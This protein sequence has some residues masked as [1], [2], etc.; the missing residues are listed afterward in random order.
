MVT[1][2]YDLQT[3]SAGTII[4]VGTDRWYMLIGLC[5]SCSCKKNDNIQIQVYVAYC[6][7]DE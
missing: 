4:V 2:P 5:N 1:R 6:N 3:L 7:A